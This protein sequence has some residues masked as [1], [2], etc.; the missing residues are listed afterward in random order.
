[1]VNIKFKYFNIYIID[2][3]ILKS[4][5]FLVFLC[6]LMFS[7]VFGLYEAS[8]PST[9]DFYQEIE[10]TSAYDLDLTGYLGLSTDFYPDAYDN[11]VRV[12]HRQLTEQGDYTLDFS[13]TGNFNCNDTLNATNTQNPFA[14]GDCPDL[15]SCYI[16]DTNSGSTDLAWLQTN[17][18][19]DAGI[20]L[21]FTAWIDKEVIN[22]EY[23][24]LGVFYNSSN[25]KYLLLNQRGTTIDYWNDLTLSN[26]TYGIPGVQS[27]WVT[28]DFY[29]EIRPMNSISCVANP[30]YFAENYMFYFNNS[31]ISLFLTNISAC[32]I[33][34]HAVHSSVAT[35][36]SHANQN[37]GE[38]GLVAHRTISAG[39][40]SFTPGTIR[41]ISTNDT[42]YAD[43]NDYQELV[44]GTFEDFISYS[45]GN[46]R[47]MG[48][49]NYA[50]AAS[51]VSWI[52]IYPRGTN[53]GKENYHSDDDFPYCYDIN[54]DYLEQTDV[55]RS[56]S[57]WTRHC[58]NNQTFINYLPLQTDLED[59][60][61]YN[62]AWLDNATVIFPI[63]IPFG[64]IETYRIYYSIN[65]D[66]FYYPDDL[67]KSWG[68]AIVEDAIEE[69]NIYWKRFGSGS[70]WEP[71]LLW[72]L[73]PLTFGLLCDRNS[74]YYGTVKYPD[75][76]G[77]LTIKDID[78]NEIVDG[79][80]TINEEFITSVA[81]DPNVGWIIEISYQNIYSNTP[82]IKTYVLSADTSGDGS[83]FIED[84]SSVASVLS[85]SLRDAF[86]RFVEGTSMF[87]EGLDILPAE[88]EGGGTTVFKTVND[89]FW[90]RT[91]VNTE[92][93]EFY[94]WFFY[95]MPFGETFEWLFFLKK[96]TADV[97]CGSC[98]DGYY[99]AY[100]NWTVYNNQFGRVKAVFQDV[101]SGVS[102]NSTEGRI[103]NALWNVS[104]MNILDTYWSELNT[105]IDEIVTER[106]HIECEVPD[107]VT[108]VVKFNIFDLDY[109]TGVEELYA[110]VYR[111][112]DSEG[113]AS[114]TFNDRL[115][116]P[117]NYLELYTEAVI[118]G[119]FLLNQKLWAGDAYTYFL[120][121]PNEYRAEC[122][123]EENPT[124][125]QS[126]LFNY[127]YQ[128]DLN[129]TN[130]CTL[131]TRE[132]RYGE[133]Q[134]M[135]KPCCTG[136]VCES[137][138]FSTYKCVTDLSFGSLRLY[139]EP[140][141]SDDD[142]NIYHTDGDPMYC[143][144]RDEVEG[145]SLCMTEAGYYSA[146]NVIINWFQNLFRS[147]VGVWVDF[148]T[149]IGIIIFAIVAIIFYTIWNKF[150]E[151]DQQQ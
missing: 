142:C 147:I 58:E 137:V 19:H 128:W 144:L 6:G 107:G 54:S 135:L 9:Y 67:T 140:C 2:M 83:R 86:D 98:G 47:F 97:P 7:P 101:V 26:Y 56:A 124:L 89:T 8:P 102:S 62:T 43:G 122:F 15:T 88:I 104:D 90:T 108:T 20:A 134:E 53:L 48:V 79:G 60:K 136:S 23:N 16:D 112:T 40:G 82:T 113:V 132:C 143:F 80:L 28:N 33:G 120:P 116:F 125:N 76:N 18:F 5:L 131:H 21:A 148:W 92:G 55:S 78:G 109:D 29:V 118:V 44:G 25:G 111:R 71:P 52:R 1:L 11:N 32:Q 63:D 75:L 84:L 141:E 36:I 17:V 12:Y 70:T 57:T 35:I 49:E 50:V 74:F 121:G 66:S 38:L 110:Q 72:F 34:S 65:N 13:C 61:Y 126:L 94:A 145:V 3:N 99:Y 42:N 151:G 73:C 51:T 100:A 93:R 64:E 39:Q 123:I 146:G 103:G 129:S 115:A 133:T 81:G 105:T 30:L 59:K 46:R 106:F 14:I 119:F 41:I 77:T 27:S 37:Q 68:G 87:Y 10:V 96:V 45:T 130:Y 127:S 139:G 4:A 69:T 114:I 117:E 150:D 95:D 149:F 22:G 31:D 138:G 91:A 24:Y 85:I